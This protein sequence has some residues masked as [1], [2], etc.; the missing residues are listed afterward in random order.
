LNKLLTIFFLP[1]FAFSS[2]QFDGYVKDDEWSDAEIYD[3]PYEIDPSYNTDAEHSTDVLIKNDDSN[4]YVAFKAYG[5]KEFIRA[6]IRS[7]DGINWLD[8]QVAIGI[9]T[10]GDGRYYIRFS[11]NPLGSIGD[12]KVDNNDDFDGSYNVE[13]DAKAHITDYGYEVEFKIPFSSLNFPEGAPQ[14]WKLML[15]RKLYNKGLESRYL[16]YKKIDGAGCIICQSTDSYL[17]ENIVKKNK[18]RLIPSF[19][20]NSVRQKNSEGN[21]N[22]EPIN[23]DI[24]IGGEYELNGNT[25]EFTIN[26]DFSQVEAD[27][28]KI[29]INS[30]TALRFEERRIF[31]NEGKD[32][33]SSDLSTVYTRSINN[34]DYAMK[35]YNR[36]EKHSYYF[37]DAEDAQ[38]PIIVPGYQR[39]YSGLLGKSH[40]NIFSYN[41]NIEKGQNI[42][43][44]ATNRDFEEGGNSSLFSLKGNFLFNEIYNTRFELVSTAMD[45]PIS[46]IINTTNV[47]KEHTYNLDGESFE[48]YGG[49]FGIS[50]D[51]ENWSTRYYFATK[52]PN[53]RSDLGFTTENNW[54]KHSVEHKYKY[55][56]DG[57]V[58]KG[59]V[60]IRKDLMQDYDGVIIDQE[61]VLSARV[62]LKN[63]FNVNFSWDNSHKISQ[64]GFVFNDVKDYNFGVSYSPSE[65][66]WMRFGYDWGDSVARNIDV[67]EIGKRTNYSF[68]SSFQ[69]NDQFRLQYNFRKNQLENQTTKEN[70]FSG[71]ITSLKGT[72]Q[73]DKDSFFKVVHEYNNFNDDS[74]TQALFQ[75]QP[76]SAT[77]F[78]FGGTIDQE[79]IEG[80]WE[81]EGS[82]IYMKLQ[83]LFNFD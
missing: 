74:Y 30:T 22:E 13:F 24:S 17:V 47:S 2:I 67:P 55:R 69:I 46:D 40:A 43:F 15:S 28:S 20:T 70:Y 23:S 5:N 50:R 25:F 6:N 37:L 75:W 57:F 72:Y 81:V 73:L 49:V 48:G 27:Q 83:Y 79:D 11:A 21:M 36:G 59:N 38:T 54:K 8:D 4:L 35:V 76:D 42:G 39:S 18:K 82:Q 34:P 14:K 65:K 44:L 33:L 45:E 12:N 66:F 51:T 9:D 60:E 10:F 58:R 7:R 19:T 32:F 26:P 31:F 1:F 16:N 52:S 56:S 41:Y 62:E 61:T 80:T 77:I 29:N 3:L 53:Y 71:Y 78:Y 68:N 63:Q 64:E